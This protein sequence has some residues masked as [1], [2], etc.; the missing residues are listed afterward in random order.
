M[1][2]SQK[3]EFVLQRNGR[4]HLNRRGRKFSRLLTAEGCASAVVM[5]DMPCSE[6][7]WR[8]LAT[9]SFRQFPLYVPSRASPC[10][11]TFQLDSMYKSAKFLLFCLPYIESCFINRFS[12]KDT[13]LS[14][15]KGHPVQCLC[16]YRWEAELFISNPLKTSA[17]ER[18]GCSVTCPGR[19]TPEKATG[20]IV[21]EVGWAS[22]PGWTYTESF[23][24]TRVN[25]QVCYQVHWT[26]RV[27]AVQWVLY[28]YTYYLVLWL[29]LTFLS[30]CIIIRFK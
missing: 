21:Q 17:L 4:V 16:R 13:W 2:H 14:T 30:P 7:V 3:L 19:F 28:D 24:S 23:P 1:A 22:G 5:L 6:V 15:D 8:V 29:D 12:L 18:G 26:A 11:I 25:D 9:H 20:F 10:A 27:C